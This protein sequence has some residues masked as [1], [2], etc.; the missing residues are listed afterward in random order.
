MGILILD[1]QSLSVPTEL[2]GF[3]PDDPVMKLMRSLHFL[4]AES[5]TAGTSVCHNIG[6]ASFQEFFHVP[7]DYNAYLVGA[8][9]TE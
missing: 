1:I 2:R 9:L 6:L 8:W 3:Y 5:R 7:R 4:W